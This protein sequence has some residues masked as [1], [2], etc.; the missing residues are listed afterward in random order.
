MNK[1][2]NTFAAIALTIAGALAM[3]QGNSINGLLMIVLA[4]QC[5]M[6]NEMQELLDR[7]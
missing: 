3:L 4:R 1:F 7:Q 6:S 2:L 5:V